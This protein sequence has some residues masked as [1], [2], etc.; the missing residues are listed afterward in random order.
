[1][2]RK[3]DILVM[4]ISLHMYACSLYVVQILNFNTHVESF[5]FVPCRAYS[6]LLIPFQ[7][8][9]GDFF[10]WKVCQTIC[11]HEAVDSFEI[12]TTMVSYLPILNGLQLL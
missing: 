2:C 3:E 7:Y 1:M 10:Q 5:K 4:L 11:I 9:K 12:N 6:L 8:L